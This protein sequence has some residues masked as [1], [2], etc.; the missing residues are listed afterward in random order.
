[1]LRDARYGLK[2]ATAT[3][4][5]MTAAALPQARTAET[6]RLSID[7]I[8]AEPAIRRG[9]DEIGGHGRVPRARHDGTQED[10]LEC[11]VVIGQVGVGLSEVRDDLRHL[12]LERAVGAGED[13]PMVDRIGLAPENRRGPDLDAQSFQRSAV[14]GPQNLAPHQE[15]GAKPF[16]KGCVWPVVV[17]A[18]AHGRGRGKPGR[19]RR[20]A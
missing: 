12:E 7:S 10:C 17:G 14:A 4:T 5:I 16:H 18:P 11:A 6:R 9:E 8:R 15:P 2:A 19:S 1:M 20:R 13:A 3:G